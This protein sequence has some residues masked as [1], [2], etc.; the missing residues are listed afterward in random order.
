MHVEGLDD[1]MVRL[2]R[3]CTPGAGRRDHGLRHPR[4]RRLG[5]PHRLRQRRQPRTH[6]ERL[7]EVEWD[8]DQ[9]ATFV[10]SVEVEALDRSKLLRDV[11]QVLSEHH[12]NILSCTSQTTRPGGEVPLRLRARRP[13]P[14]RVDPAGGEADRQRVRGLPRAPGTPARRSVRRHFGPRIGD[15]PGTCSG[16]RDVDD[17]HARTTTSAPKG[18]HDC[19]PRFRRWVDLVATFAGRARRAG[20]GLIVT[21]IFE[22]LEVFERVGTST[23][24]VKKEMYD[25]VDKGGRR[26]ALR[27]E[28]T[29]PVVRAFVQHRPTLPWKVWYVAP[30]FRYERPQKGATASTGNSGSKYSAPTTRTSTWRSSPSH[31]FYADLGSR[32]SRLLVNSMGTTRVGPYLPR[33]APRVLLDH[34]DVLG[35]E[36]RRRVEENP[37]RVLDAKRDDWSDLIERAPQITA[38]LS[39]ASRAHFEGVQHS[40][41][42]LAS[43]YELAPRLVRG[44]DYY[45]STTF[46]FPSDALDAAQNAIGGGGRYDQLAEEMGGP[47]TP[48]IGFGIGIERV[49]IARRR[50]SSHAGARRSRR[51]W[52]TDLGRKTTP[53]SY[54]LRN[55]GGSG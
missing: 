2:S 43:D 21:P 31:R 22:H 38:H 28:G 7:I 23:D 5:A 30:N 15:G 4:P 40:L 13:Q 26:I 29:A 20:F 45:T 49:L 42:A 27:P 9:T 6:A 55:C 46:E 1:V 18:T 54:S 25:F 24:V 11:A 44:F 16:V 37:L 8:H 41:D 36:G 3:C 12:V 51:S 10:V 35:D 14:S 32:A 52:S 50:G 34:G 47:P 53:R 33:T 48:G 17:V 19:F 39:D